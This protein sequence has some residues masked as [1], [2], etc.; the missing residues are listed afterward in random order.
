MAGRSLGIAIVWT[1]ALAVTAAQHPPAPDY[2]WNLPPSLVNVV[3]AAALTWGN[4]SVTHLEEQA[5][6]PMFGE[7]PIELGLRQPG[8]ALLARLRAE[9]RYGPLFASAFG[10]A[11]GADAILVE[12][13]TQAL[14]SFERT[15]ISAR[16]PYDRYRL[17]RGETALSAAAR[18][19]ETIFFSQPQSCFRC[20]GGFNLSG[21]I[22]TEGHRG[23]GDV[24]FH[25]TGLYNIA[26]ALSYPAPNTGVYE[27]T[28]KPEDVGTY[29]A[30]RRG[31]ASG[32]AV[33]Q[34]VANRRVAAIGEHR[35]H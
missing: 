32:S 13:V 3:Y 22:A 27:V 10:G 1:A 26:G 28:R 20:H 2:A 23:D 9:P 17:D 25:N 12:H 7:H 14:A 33:R 29:K 16:A 19:G 5:L 11:G 24:E 31:V 35:W 15:I 4:P 18:R 6:V 30:H 21:A 8:T 34:P